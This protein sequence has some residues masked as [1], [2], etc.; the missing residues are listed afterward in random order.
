VRSLRLAETDGELWQRLTL[1][2]EQA[3]AELF[4]R[5]RDAV[6]TYAFRRTASWSMAEDVTQATFTMLWRRA[7]QGR[8]DRL[9]L[10]SARPA[11][12]AM[13][14]D[15]CGNANRTRR[16]QTALVDRAA[17][18]RSD[19]TDRDDVDRWIETEITMREIR[20][21]LRV[22]PRNQ[23]ELIELVAWAD[24]PLTQAAAVLGIPSGTAKSRLS[25]ARARL[26]QA[27]GAALLHDS[28]R[29]A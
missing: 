10:D 3:F 27:G 4:A 12:F 29:S 7:R 8:I 28:A 14:R 9:R 16:R 2:D 24:L 6:Y 21:L 17:S 15:E 20:R 25:R 23:R 19:A 22:L 18:H 13:A 11:L 5:H 1:A 26:L